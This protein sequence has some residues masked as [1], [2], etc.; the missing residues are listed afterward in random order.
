MKTVAELLK[1]KPARRVVSVRPE[2]SVLEAIKVLKKGSTEQ[3]AARAAALLFESRVLPEHFAEI[4]SLAAASAWAALTFEERAGFTATR[5]SA[6][7][8]SIP[9]GT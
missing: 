7:S 9:C 1:A 5:A 4:K 8:S 3:L 6:S 2:Q